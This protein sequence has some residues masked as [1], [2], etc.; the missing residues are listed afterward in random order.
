MKQITQID[1]KQVA[2]IVYTDGSTWSPPEKPP[3]NVIRPR[4]SY[5]PH[6]SRTCMCN[7]CVERRRL[8]ELRRA[9]P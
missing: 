9:A 7:A 4:Q 1:D 6:K 3:S 2:P 5:N 8:R